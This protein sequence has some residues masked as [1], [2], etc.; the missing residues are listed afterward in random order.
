MGKLITILGG[1]LVV[2]GGL[3]YGVY[4]HHHGCPLAGNCS[5]P[6]AVADCCD[7]AACPYSA[8]GTS[9]GTND[10][11]PLSGAGTSCCP[12]TKAQVVAATCPADGDGCCESAGAG[13]QAVAGA[14][15]SAGGK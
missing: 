12:A 13:L 1:C 10:G 5:A 4:T 9:A 11:C 2:A 8:V 14:A 3:A 6:A 15:L 7:E